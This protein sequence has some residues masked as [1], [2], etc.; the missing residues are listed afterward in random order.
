[1]V[2]QSWPF[3]LVAATVALRASLNVMQ[4]NAVT[5]VTLVFLLYQVC[6]W[7]S[8]PMQPL[9][10]LAVQLAMYSDGLNASSSLMTVFFGTFIFPELVEA[11]VSP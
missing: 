3:K 10:Q 1:M 2:L 9:L 6:A 11:V 7:S 5:S 8:A 4:V